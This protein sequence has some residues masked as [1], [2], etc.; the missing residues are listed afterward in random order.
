M[1]IIDILEHS[2]PHK[3]I[4]SSPEAV[5]TQDWGISNTGEIVGISWNFPCSLIR[6]TSHFLASIISRQ[7]A[8]LVWL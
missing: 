8:M 5:L 2:V 6:I 4:V 1:A 7:G 3:A